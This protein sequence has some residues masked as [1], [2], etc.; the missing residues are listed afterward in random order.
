MLMESVL[1]ETYAFTFSV[2]VPIGIALVIVVLIIIGVGVSEK[3]IIFGAIFV[4]IIIGV[5]TIFFL[6][7]D[8]VKSRR[9]V[10]ERW[11][12][13]KSV[14]QVEWR[15]PK[16]GN[17]HFD[18]VIVLD[19]RKYLLCAR[20]VIVWNLFDG[21]QGEKCYYVHIN[22]DKKIDDVYDVLWGADLPLSYYDYWDRW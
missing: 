6:Q 1:T 18:D 7:S 9:K 4:T 21:T 17:K 10:N 15:Y 20:E 11:L 22:N 13:G 3:K 2:G 8:F 12:L 19:G 5:I 16:D 14:D